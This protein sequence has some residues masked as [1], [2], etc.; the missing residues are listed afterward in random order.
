MKK[1]RTLAIVCAAALLLTTMLSG[2]VL[3]SVAEEKTTLAPGKYDD[4][5][6]TDFATKFY[7]S[8]TDGAP[9]PATKVKILD[10]PNDVVSGATTFGTFMGVEMPLRARTDSCWAAGGLQYKVQPETYIATALVYQSTLQELNK[11]YAFQISKDGTNWEAAADVKFVGET[12]DGSGSYNCYRAVTYIPADYNYYRVICP[13][14]KYDYTD[15]AE[16]SWANRT[17]NNAQNLVDGFSY[18]DIAY[19]LGGSLASAYDLSTYRFK[20][21]VPEFMGDTLEPGCIDDLSTKNYLT[22][23]YLT[24]TGGAPDPETRIEILTPGTD[25]V[26][27]ATTFGTFMGIEV[28][29]R[30]RTD[31]CWAAGGLQYKVL[32]NTYIATALVYQGTLSALNNRYAFQ[33]SKDGTNWEAA[34]DV[35]FVTETDEGSYH[36]NRAVTKIPADYNYY[37]VICP[38]YKYDYASTD[39]LTWPNRTSVATFE[40]G[41]AYSDISYGLGCSVASAYDLSTVD[42]I[43]AVADSPFFVDIKLDLRIALKDAEKINLLM[44]EDGVTKDTYKE[45]LGAAQGILA[46]SDATEQEVNTALK[47]LQDAIAALLPVQ[48]PDRATIEYADERLVLKPGIAEFFKDISLVV[49]DAEE[50]I[51][52]EQQWTWKYFYDAYMYADQYSSTT[53][54]GFWKNQGIASK[55]DFV[56]AQNMEGVK[57][58]GKNVDAVVNSWRNWDGAYAQYKVYANSYINTAVIVDKTIQAE[59]EGVGRGQLFPDIH[60]SY[61]FQVSADGEK[62]TDISESVTINK[63]G[64][65]DTDKYAIYNCVVKIPANNYF[66]RIVMPGAE[67]LTP[68]TGWYGGSDPKFDFTQIGP[69]IAT[70][71]DS[72]GYTQMSD[73]TDLVEAY[74]DDPVITSKDEQKITINNG[75]F[76]VLQDMTVA[77]VLAAI[78]VS[79]GS[80]V[81]LKED[82]SPADNSDTMVMGMKVDL[83]DK[84]GVSMKDARNVPYLEVTAGSDLLAVPTF[85]DIKLVN[86]APK[87]VEGLKLPTIIK[88]DAAN[89]SFDA[90]IAWDVDS[91]NYKPEEYTTQQFTVKGVLNLPDGVT[92]G[93][94]FDLNVS[95]N[96]TVD[97]VTRMSI[98]TRDEKYAVVDTEEEIVTVPTGITVG[99]LLKYLKPVGDVTIVI[100]DGDTD[101]T[102]MKTVVT[103]DMTVDFYS[104]SSLMGS[105]SIVLSDEMAKALEEDPGKKD[106]GKE[107]EP[108]EEDDPTSPDTGVEL[109]IAMMAL[110]AIAGASV[111]ATRKKHD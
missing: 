102:D 79:N 12:T 4:L 3:N 75:Y 103:E 25:F 49:V 23:F 78:D 72:T 8:T 87:T 46:K 86:G 53:K 28:P 82:G 90:E 77:D 67:S 76:K 34:A 41:F 19:G 70:M 104:A 10:A 45:K 81:I 17:N 85:A 38:G 59:T 52:N 58:F 33:I 55:Y 9:D 89:G 64:C 18:S 56:V 13:G 40:D 65:T 36:V 62:W 95:V 110:A 50:A 16:L 108:G 60:K 111:L 106:P 22:K 99:E 109:P 93:Q 44:Y 27:G 68:E 73:F 71:N 21:N 88:I 5:S 101:I 66:L 96:V 105:Y 57:Y 26:S 32:P 7:L 61:V 6:T 31:S 15:T 84:N 43:A 80:A 92:N 1:S 30:A 83:L 97:A 51:V 37:R 69:S 47:D 91:V 63:N 42:K 14:Y 98:T 29:L 48:I 11:R 100:A 54:E 24:T 39:D 94:G 74:Y 20:K 35:K 2:L 107:D